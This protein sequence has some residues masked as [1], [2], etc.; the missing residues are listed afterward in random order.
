MASKEYISAL[1][2]NKNRITITPG[3]SLKPYLNGDFFV[4]YD[5]PFDLSNIGDEVACI[6]FVLSTAAIV[7]CSGETLHLDKLDANLAER[8][9]AIKKEY[10]NMYPTIHWDGEILVNHKVNAVSSQGL[11]GMLFSGGLDS[12][13]SALTIQ[14]E[15]Y[16]FT[17]NGAD[18]KLNAEYPWKFM[19]SHTLDFVKKYHHQ[20]VFVYS[21][22]KEFLN[23]PI[24]H[25]WHR[26][27]THWY[28]HVQFGPALIGLTAPI[29]YKGGGNILYISSGGQT[30]NL[31]RG[32]GSS[33]L[34]DE[35]VNFGNVTV[36][37]YGN[38]TRM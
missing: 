20:P 6:P 22:F 12:I 33:K 29:M 4:E 16:L 31:V 34:L 38:H 23:V 17:I 14:G 13:H 36:H 25:S 19:K 2:K 24:L 35:Q 10:E 7:W 37:H 21:N 30:H 28:S 18:S 5:S 11:D 15:K 27:I 1:E 32:W 26:E 3:E 9:P 8:L